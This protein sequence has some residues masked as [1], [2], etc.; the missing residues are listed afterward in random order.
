MDRKA[1]RGTILILLGWHLCLFSYSQEQE[2]KMQLPEIKIVTDTATEA[3]K[4]AGTKPTIK[5]THV[6][7]YGSFETLKGKVLNVKPADYRVT[8]YI[9]VETT[10]WTK[11]Y[12]DNPLTI[13][14]PDG[15][16]VCNITT[17][18]FDEMATKIAAYLVPAGYEVPLASGGWFLQKDLGKKAV[19]KVEIK[20]PIVRRRTK[21]KIESEK[22]KKLKGICYGPFR[23]K[24]DP[25]MGVFPLAE[26]MEEDIGLL[27]HLCLALRTYGLSHTLKKI[28]EMCEKAGIDCYPGAWISQYDKETEK[29]IEALIQIGKQGLKRV[30]AL[31]VG[32]EVL[33][34]KDMSSEK[35]I[36]YIRQVK[37]ATNLPVSTAEIWGVWLK[38]PELA[39]EVDFLLVNIHPYWEGQS[40]EAA[41]S[42]TIERWKQFKRTFPSKKIVIGETGWPSA[43]KTIGR[44]VPNQKNQARFLQEFYALAEKEG[45]EYFYFEAFDESWKDKFEGGTGG[46]W[47][48]YHSNGSLKKELT[49]LL[50]PE[51]IR[52]IKRTKKR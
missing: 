29:E 26:G 31:I 24:E 38:H 22:I 7:D 16:W 44:A 2:T 5:F 40:I 3:T 37:K 23:D 4:K 12:W 47:G 36:G 45:V 33:L 17:G 13:I 18:G 21:A 48:I 19:A 30:K 43:G 51:S 1:L 20:R 50:P 49:E 35:L 10:W 41:A 15:T 34:T 27:K 25:E 42:S 46:H 52:G 32:N 39:K 11:P 6:P 8:V 9:Q 28:P 14:N